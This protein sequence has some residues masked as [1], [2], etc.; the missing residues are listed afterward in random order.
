MQ[1]CCICLLLVGVLGM[2][3]SAGA[4]GWES[5]A[6]KLF[7]LA[8]LAVVVLLIAYA[9]AA[10]KNWM[11]WVLVV[12]LGVGL[13]LLPWVERAPLNTTLGVIEAGQYALH[14]VI[15]VLL[16]LPTTA[17]WFRSEA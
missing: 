5:P 11:R 8:A 9:L 4:G 1:A 7:W 6:K 16:L 15:V 12:W 17:T 14:L 2:T 3:R 13:L 10:R